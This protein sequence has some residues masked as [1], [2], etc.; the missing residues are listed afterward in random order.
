VR[1]LKGFGKRW[2]NVWEKE[3]ACGVKMKPVYIK[4]SSDAEAEDMR[5]FCLTMGTIA[6]KQ[7]QTLLLL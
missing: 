6:E 4:W 1:L 3:A 2:R 5:L 7:G